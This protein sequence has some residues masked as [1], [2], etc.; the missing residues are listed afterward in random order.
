MVKENISQKFRLKII[1]E[2]KLFPWRNRT[3]GTNESTAQ[4]RLS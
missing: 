1:D 4:K 2:T 3:K